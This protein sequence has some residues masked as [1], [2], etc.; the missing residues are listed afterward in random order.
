VKSGMHRGHFVQIRRFIDSVQNGTEPPV[1]AEDARD[2]LKLWL[3]ITSRLS[4]GGD[5][6]SSHSGNPNL[7][8]GEVIARRL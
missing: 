4:A 6:R 3:D 7:A 8:S 1:T 5:S 2:V